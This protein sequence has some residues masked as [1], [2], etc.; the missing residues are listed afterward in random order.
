MKDKIKKQIMKDKIKYIYFERYRITGYG[1]TD[2]EIR[3]INILLIKPDTGG[4]DSSG[5]NECMNITE[6]FGFPEKSYFVVD[7][8]WVDL[9]KYKY[10]DNEL[11]KNI[12]YVLNKLENVKDT[13]LSIDELHFIQSEKIYIPNNETIVEYIN[14]KLKDKTIALGWNRDI[15]EYTNIHI[16]TKDNI[17]VDLIYNDNGNELCKIIEIPFSEF[18]K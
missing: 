10:N 9:D 15:F 4:E 6:R 1:Q 7:Q 2:F 5:I 8:F 12:K 11:N 13:R 14:K 17:I 18:Q 3:N 16:K